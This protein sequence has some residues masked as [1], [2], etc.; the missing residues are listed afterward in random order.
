MFTID[1]S[2]KHRK[3]IKCDNSINRL[4]IVIFKHTYIFKSK[5]TKAKANLLY[6]RKQSL[7]G[8]RDTLAVIGV[9]LVSGRVFGIGSQLL[10]SLHHVAGTID[11]LFTG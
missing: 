1:I 3:T 9:E 6:G 8:I 2:F 4:I 10:G 7:D 11:H 5:P